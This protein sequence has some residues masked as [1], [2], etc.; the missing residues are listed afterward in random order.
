MLHFAIAGCPC[1]EAS[2]FLLDRILRIQT[3]FVG[4]AD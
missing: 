3:F 4:R 2:S 1:Q